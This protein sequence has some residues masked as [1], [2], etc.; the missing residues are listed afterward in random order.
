[1]IN[2]VGCPP[3]E[4]ASF[5]AAVPTLRLL[6]LVSQLLL[7]LLE[8]LGNDQPSGATSVSWF[9]SNMVSKMIIYSNEIRFSVE[10]ENFA[11]RTTLAR[12]V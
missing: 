5:P 12:G 6:T 4:A 1:M 8:G 2:K 7:E 11:N 9:G 10:R 3:G